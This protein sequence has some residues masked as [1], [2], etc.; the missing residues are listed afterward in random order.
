[1]EVYLNGVAR[2]SEEKGIESSWGHYPNTQDFHGDLVVGNSFVENTYH[3][4]NMKI[5][6][7]MIWEERL[8][9]S[10]IV[11]LTNAYIRLN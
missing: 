8:S 10:D 2:P 5:D 7:I 9:S 6:E 4:G 11:T 1:M 3:P